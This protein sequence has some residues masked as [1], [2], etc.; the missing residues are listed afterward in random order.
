MIGRSGGLILT[1]S[2][3]ERGAKYGGGAIM[4]LKKRKWSKLCRKWL[5]NASRVDRNELELECGIV[6]AVSEFPRTNVSLKKKTHGESI[7]E[8]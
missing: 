1:C 6:G 8:I 7:L 5:P 4:L 3:V 2:V